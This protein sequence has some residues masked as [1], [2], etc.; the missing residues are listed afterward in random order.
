[1]FDQVIFSSDGKLDRLGRS[2]KDSLRRSISSQERGVDGY[3]LDR[4]DRHRYTG[5]APLIFH[6]MEALAEF[7]RDLI[8]SET[9]CLDWL[10]PVPED[11]SAQAQ[12]G[13]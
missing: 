10:R 6:L 2:L 13:D 5:K 7:E 3:Q 8:V 4:E 1:M 11:V 9:C 12:V